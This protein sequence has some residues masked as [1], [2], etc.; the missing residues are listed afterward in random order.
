MKKILLITLTS[1]MLFSCK[2]ELE[3]PT[4]DLDL[5]TPIVHANMNINNLL[6]DTN[7]NITEDN[8][9]F[10]TLV[11]EESLID[12]NYD[13]LIHIDARAGEKTE[14]LDSVIFDDVV[15]AH[16]ATIGEAIAEIPFGTTLFPDGS[17]NS[18]PA[19][20]NMMN[21]DTMVIN[22]SEYF[23]TMNLHKGWLV[24]DLV[25]NFPTDVSNVNMT[26]KNG[27]NQ[28]TIA[29]FNFPLI[30]AGST[31]TDSSDISGKLL[32]KNLTAIIHRMDIEASA[33]PVLITYS[34]AIIIQITITDIGITE[35]TAIFPEQELAA[36]L[37][38]HI[39][40]MKGAQITEIGVK[41]GNVT[42]NVLST[43]PNGKIIYSIPSLKL[44][45]VPFYT[46]NIIPK[47]LNGE[48]TQFEFDFTGYVLDLTG[49]D[50][51]IG[52]DTVNTIYTETYSFIDSTG[53][54]ITLN[55]TDSF[56]SFTEFLFTPEYAKGYLGQDTIEITSEEKEFE[57]FNNITSSNFELKDV[58][59]K[60]SVNNYIG[61]DAQ[62][63]I[64]ELKGRNDNTQEEVTL[65][66]NETM[67][68]DRATLSNNNL[69][70]NPTFYEKVIAAE[71]FLNI[72]PNK[73]I[74]SANFYLNPYGQSATED[75]LYPEYPIEASISMGIP[76]SLIASELTFIDTSAVDLPDSDEYQIEKIYL[77]IQNGLPF[78]ADLQL[79]LLDENNTLVDTLLSNVLI[80][81]GK[82]DNNNI[83][84]N[85][86]TTTIEMDYTNFESAS[87]IV[88]IS[89]F[90]TKPMNEF[91][92]IY[93]HYG[94]DI[95]IS[96]K[97]KKTM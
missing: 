14:K 23:E 9:G 91:I 89:A 48:L 82:I 60:I 78:D 64:I 94:L 61:A 68:I 63:E 69:P 29:N 71:D 54:L 21:E 43:L 47:S 40:D 31:A 28:E 51:R 26:L 33:G 81:S 86:E 74:S 7:L 12:M 19:M 96:A 20:Q 97:V 17:T 77:T 62:L 8:N 25:N 30:P 39:F 72:L 76:L 87:K 75:F 27:N 80:N 79:I 3:K 32:D 15:I 55:H 42:L 46:E 38:E 41:E 22:A 1:F 50:G 5:I 90:T 53:E 57:I 83:V 85:E 10:I 67:Q 52:G 2:H 11:Y 36:T 66:T 84:I 4:W 45:G 56:Y 65:A 73:I 16:T 58:D 35:A 18:I 13:S 70:I 49:E 88:S 44:N 37:E 6:S 93:S 59:L 24:I 95:T 34:D 92:D